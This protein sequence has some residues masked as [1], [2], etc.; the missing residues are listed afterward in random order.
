LVHYA[1][2]SVHRL[3]QSRLGRPAGLADPGVRLLDP[4]AGTMNFVRAAWR[5]ALAAHRGGALRDL[6]R[7]HL[8]VH[9]TGIELLPD[10]HARG[11]AALRRLLQAA[12][13]NAPAERLP[14]VLGDALEPLPGIFAQPFNVVLGNP[15]W[16]GCSSNRGDWITDLLRGYRLP[17]GRQDEG[18]F[19]VDGTPL[20]ERNPKWLQ[21]DYVKF[22]RLAQVLIDRNGEGIVA[23]VLNHNF[24]D[25]PTFA[26]LR[27]SLLRTFHEVYV[28]DLHGNSRRQERG[29]VFPGVAQ[30]AAVLFLVRKAG[31]RRRVLRADLHGSRGDKLKALERSDATAT[32]WEE[33]APHPPGYLFVR[34]DRALERE[35][36]RGLPLPEI[37]PVHGTGIVTGRDAEVTAVERKTLAV[38]F[39]ADLETRIAVFLARP[40]DL[41]YV[42][43]AEGFLA[44]PRRALMAHFLAGD[45][46]G[47]IVPRQHK[48]EPGALV[49]RWIA[50]HKV[51]SACDV[52]ALFP[53]YLVDGSERRPNLAPG[54]G[55]RLG[56]LYGAEPEPEAILSCVY[57]NLYSPFY[58]RHYRELLRRSFPRISFPREPKLFATLSAL[59]RELIDLHLLQDPRLHRGRAEEIEPEVWSYRIGGYRVL[60]QWLRARR[61]RALSPPETRRFRQITEALRLTL[62]AQAKIE[63]V[64]GD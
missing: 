40:F 7:D 16:R 36:E 61:G 39:G 54:L 56:D 57:A 15:P 53:L 30:G 31:L 26:G 64:T 45:N 37:F 38:R 5:V 47:L 49:T 3:L 11:V 43:Y 12:G 55:R 63:E 41:Q 29:N 2:R 4:A 8:L 60:P 6:I 35:Y 34:G 14:A 52:S 27:R 25:A 13:C 9:F 23:F 24:L 17:D 10:V 51:V 58:R 59:G 46:V 48:E 44:R 62:E 20:G 32:A 19:R 1:V 21:D 18:Y 50:G 42:L 28:L 22:L 33:V